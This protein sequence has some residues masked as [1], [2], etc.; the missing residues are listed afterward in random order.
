MPSTPYQ[1]CAVR[2]GHRDRVSNENFLGGDPAPLPGLEG[3]AVRL[4]LEPRE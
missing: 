4:D 2:Y 1:L 3:V